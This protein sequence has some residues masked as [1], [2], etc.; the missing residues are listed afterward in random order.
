MKIIFVFCSLLYLTAGYSQNQVAITMDDVPF[1]Q[2]P[3]TTSIKELRDGN[4]QLLKVIESKEVPVAIFINE[5]SLTT[6][7]KIAILK[8]WV[9][10]PMVALG[11][12][13][14]SHKNFANETLPEFESEVVKGELLTKKLSKGTGKN[15]SYFRF[16][17]NATGKDS[18]SRFA[19]EEVLIK[20]GYKSVP[21]TIE[22]SDYLFNSLYM[23]ALK[24]G[25][26]A[27][28]IE[29][30][31]AYIKYTVELFDYF[32]GLATTRFGKNIKHIYL[33]HV[34]ALNADYFDEL[35]GR[36]KE[37]RYSFISLEDAMKDEVYANTN[38]YHG[39]HG[40][41]WMYR[42]E[43]DPVIR[44]K[45]LADSPDPD[46]KYLKEYQALTSK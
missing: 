27:K 7:D 44:Q 16:P 21:F 2:W 6:P 5:V 12:H 34:N 3:S 25:D 19:M 36:L 33:C 9:E 38:Y 32:E 11:N 4:Q 22:S 29:I 20:K 35:I 14:Y 31:Q 18:V 1:L 37:N 8:Q 41:S 15:L 39:P 13:S 28:A 42:W 46:E 10:H 40:F 45:L 17:F 43:K 23:D 26:Q 24:R 30:G